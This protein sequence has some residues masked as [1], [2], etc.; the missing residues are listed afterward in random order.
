M[1]SLSDSAVELHGGCFCSSIR[2]TIK[3][4]VAELRPTHPNATPEAAE[5][6]RFP[7]IEL[8]HCTSCRRSTG[9]IIQSWIVLPKSWVSWSLI[10]KSS[11]DAHGEPI[12]PPKQE[13]YRRFS[14]QDIV[15]PTEELCR[16]TYWSQYVSSPD[17][18]RGFCG[19][20][21]TTLT[22]CYTGPKPGWTLPERNFDVSLGSLDNESLERVRPERHGWWTDGIG[23]VREM[24]R[25]GDQS[26]GASLARH[27]TGNVRYF[28]DDHE[29]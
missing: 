5:K 6:T 21:G 27:P 4:P 18:H 2:Y 29:I 11:G 24:L 13:E 8:D 12:E 20:C 3:I 23:W 14:S 19:R 28:M 22:Y 9:S 10:P 16:S 7:L 26:N 1:T 17:V 15:E 25:F